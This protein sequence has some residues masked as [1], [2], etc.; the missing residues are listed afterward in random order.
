ARRGAGR[1]SRG[2]TLRRTRRSAPGGS[3][4]SSLPELHVVDERLLHDLLRGAAAL[5]LLHLDGLLL[6][7][8][9][10][11]EEAGDLLHAVR[12]EVP[13]VLVARVLGVTHVDGDDLVV[14]RA[15]V[16]HGH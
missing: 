3:W 13:Y 4:S 14:R 1:A 9:V 8:L 10:V 2:R 11:L 6:E 15:A 16:E 12:G 5:G 7:H